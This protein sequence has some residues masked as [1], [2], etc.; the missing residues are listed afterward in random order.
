MNPKYKLSII[1]CTYNRGSIL[2]D[3]LDSLTKQTVEV[4]NLFEVV[5]INNNST[6]NTQDIINQFTSKYP[7]F[8]YYFE[9]KQGLSHARNLGFNMAKADWVVYIDDDAKVH[10][11]F[12]E[13]VLWVIENYDF[14]CFGGMHY[15][16]YIEEKPHWLPNNFGTRRIYAEH[17]CEVSNP[18]GYAIGMVMAFKVNVLKQIGGFKAEYGMRGDNIGYS[19]ETEVQYQMQKL[20]Y[21]IGFDPELKVDHL[22]GK[23][24]Y[25]ISWHL[26]SAYQMSYD[27]N[28]FRKLNI[29]QI[30]TDFIKGLGVVLIKRLPKLL[31]KKNYY[32]QNFIIDFLSPFIILTGRIMSSFTILEKKA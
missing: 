14:D 9:K 18:R 4:N 13:R 22:V 27:L 24:K 16:W 26:K 6:D 30:T 3:C 10:S 2:S 15:A 1:I 32:W 29:I 25:L 23:H 11:G 28:S 5:I 7:N 21:K 12:V 17:I 20:N 19:E 8:K 31:I